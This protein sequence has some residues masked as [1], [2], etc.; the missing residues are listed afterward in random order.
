M[1]GQTE[2]RWLRCATAI[3][4]VARKNQNKETQCDRDRKREQGMILTT[5]ER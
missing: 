4:A 1:D 3:A 5:V 2:L